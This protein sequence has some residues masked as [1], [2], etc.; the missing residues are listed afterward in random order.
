MFFHLGVADSS[1]GILLFVLGTRYEAGWKAINPK[2][3]AVAN[4]PIGFREQHRVY[5]PTRAEYVKYHISGLIKA[6]GLVKAGEILFRRA[7]GIPGVVSVN[8]SG[9]RLDVRPC[10]SDLFVLSQIFGWEQ[11]RIEAWRL[12]MLRKVAANW[13]TT[14]ITP[15]II[16]AGANVGYSALY[17]ASLFPGVCVLAIEPDLRSFEILTRHVRAN[18]QIKP[19]HAALWSHD[20]GL[21]LKTSKQGSWGAHVAEG[22]GTPS[23]RLDKLVASVPNTRPL[24]IKLDIEGAEREVVSSCP[25]VFAEA[26]C[27]IVEPHDFM[28]PGDACLTPLY[29]IASGRRFDT[30]LSEENL[31]LFA[32]DE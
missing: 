12:S 4:Q 14:G 3:L 18:E 32:V 16:D 8:V 26:K 5:V 2:R 7:L 28:Y 21:E 1:S 20:R 29:E 9:Y 10:D 31:L 19:V 30:I 27:I 24:I 17:F 6:A 22:V 11:Y 15:L 23:Q 13:Q 25:E